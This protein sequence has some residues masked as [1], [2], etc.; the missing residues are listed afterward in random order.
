[1]AQHILALLQKPVVR[2][3]LVLAAVLGLGTFGFYYLELVEHGSEKQDLLAALY[4]TVVTMTTVGYGDITPV[5]APGRILAMAVM[6]SGLFL[7]SILTGSLASFLVEQ[8]AQKRKGLLTVKLTRHVIIAGWNFHGP[9]LVKTLRESK[10]LAEHSLVLVNDLGEEARD[11]VAQI[12]NLGDRLQFVKGIAAHE[13][14]MRKARPEEAKM[15]FILRQGGIPSKDAD[16][17]SIYTALTVRSL[18]PKVP[19]YGEVVFTENGPHMLR[20]G[21]NEVV[22]G[23]ELSG[24]ILGVMGANP[25][26]WTLLQN[27][28]GLHGPELL[29]FHP[30]RPEEKHMVWR[31]FSRILRDRTGALPLA[32]CHTSKTLSLTDVL[33]EG[34]GLDRFI[35]ELFESAGQKTQLGQQG[36]QVII[37]PPDTTKLADFDGVL[38]L[39]PQTQA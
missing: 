5:S 39:K 16:Q 20:A 7:V 33:D 15:V 13:G 26:M 2:V 19:I 6:V 10:V 27:M 35:L 4:W 9:G 30:I 21:V 18:S 8:K 12:L 3:L 24:R 28:M 29:D 25:S 11:E 34:S 23:G 32:L 1:M 38:L 14:V 36:P 31:E 17:Q 22:V 37:N